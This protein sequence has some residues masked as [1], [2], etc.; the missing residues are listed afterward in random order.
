MI[1]VCMAT[2]NG[3]Q[4]IREQ[5]ESILSQL[6]ENDEV[7][8][9]DDGS[10]DNTLRIVKDLKDSRI[11][12]FNNVA[13]HGVVPN[14]ENALRHASG[15]VIFLADQDDVWLPHKVQTVLKHLEHCDWV[16]HNV[17]M[18]D[19]NLN[20]QGIDFFTL[21]NTKYGF[22][23]NIWKMRYLGCTMA[24]KKEALKYIMPFPKDILWHDMWAAAILHAKYNGE[25]IRESLMYYRR[26]GYNASP[27]SE[28]SGWSWF[29]RL[30][31]RCVILWNAI[32]RLNG[33]VFGLSFCLFCATH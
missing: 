17:E 7:I 6:G 10:K 33:R 15:D 14:F 3:E 8:I 19:G 30:E 29:F 27:T 23:K 20:L 13:P 22:W 28:K 26:H 5:L 32:L 12:A 1:S 18:A 11:K 21:R 9:S 4:Y 25:L 16:A 24:F 2:Y 31:Y